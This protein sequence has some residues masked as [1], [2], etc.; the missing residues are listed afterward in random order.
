M[1]DTTSTRDASVE[2]DEPLMSLW[3]L[4]ESLVAACDARCYDAGTPEDTCDCLC[5]GHNHSV[6]FATALRQTRAESHLWIRA[7]ARARGLTDFSATTVVEPD[8]CEGPPA[9]V[10]SVSSE[11]QRPRRVTPGP[12]AAPRARPPA[13]GSGRRPRPTRVRS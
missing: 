7:Y 10:W 11:T 13:D 9:S 4:E 2:G 5:G 12:K 3:T 1:N 6:G 8:V